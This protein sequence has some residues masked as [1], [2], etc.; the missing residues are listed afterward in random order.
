M[1]GDH[2]FN[3]GDAFL[4]CLVSQHGTADDVT[5]SE[6]TGCGCLILRIHL[7]KAP[8]IRG[9]VRSFQPEIFRAGLASNGNQNTVTGQ[10]VRS[11]N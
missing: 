7:N 1:T 4:F 5:D 2:F 10:R 9:D 6:D 3:A 8:T 11:I